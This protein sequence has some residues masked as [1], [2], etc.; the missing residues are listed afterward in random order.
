MTQLAKA[1]LWLRALCAME[2]DTEAALPVLRVTGDEDGAQE[3]WN[4]VP[5]AGKKQY[6]LLSS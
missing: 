5:L 2:E 4:L 6:R 1:Q 3:S